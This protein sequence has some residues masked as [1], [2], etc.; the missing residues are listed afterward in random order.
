[1]HACSLTGS[2]FFLIRSLGYEV[3]FNLLHREELGIIKIPDHPVVGEV[4]EQ[5]GY[6][7][8]G[9]GPDGKGN[10]LAVDPRPQIDCE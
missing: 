4:F 8:V 3:V 7:S 10:V 5:K 2:G 1:M 9:V 6:P